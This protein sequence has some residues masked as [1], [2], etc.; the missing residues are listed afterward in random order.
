MSESDMSQI[1]DLPRGGP[2]EVYRKSASFN[3]KKMKLFFEELDLI[4]YKVVFFYYKSFYKVKM[5]FLFRDRCFE[6]CGYLAS[7]GVL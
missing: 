1:E 2:L 7:L 6:H 5:A 3:W 4:Q